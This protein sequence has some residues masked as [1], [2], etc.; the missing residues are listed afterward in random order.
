MSNRDQRGYDRQVNALA[1]APM[2]KRTPQF[3]S[4][5]L[6]WCGAL[7]C[8][9]LLFLTV[10]GRHPNGLQLLLPGLLMIMPI[11]LLRK[12]PLP[13]LAL[14]LIGS[15]G[16]A[17]TVHSY[18]IGY[19]QIFSAAIALCLIVAT[20]ARWV[21][22]LAAVAAFAVQVFSATYYATGSQ[23]FTTVRVFSGN[24]YGSQHFTT[25]VAFAALTTITAWVIGQSVRERRGHAEAL[26]AQGA[27]QA[28]MAERLRIARELHDVIA[29]S[30]GIIA[31]QAGVGR[32]VIDTQPA[33]ARNALDAI[34]A[35]SREA[36]AGLR[37]T[38]TALRQTQPGAD[39]APLGPA[40][41]LADLGRLAAATQ[42]A[43]VRMD[44]RWTG[45]RRPLP[46]DIDLAAFR[47]IQE[48]VTNVVCHAA[49]QDC[50][51]IIDQAGDELALEIVDDGQGAAVPGTGYG[52]TGMRERVG[53][54]HGQFA[55]GLRPEGGFRVA[56]RLPVPAPAR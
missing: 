5:I 26:R 31:I 7:A 54:L 14:I 2:L 24:Y 19:L 46:A 42:D 22:A 28:V 20:H 38:L 33:E 11:A 47:I 39:L 49:T 25:V 15:F 4:S 9:V 27:A 48:A 32:R 55:A 40:P 37:R 13:A 44:V 43:G 34:E 50:R 51:V 29:H 41:G 53:L 18:E 10:P 36:L 35:T 56:A 12:R 1:P 23:H 30:V 16:A 8:P 6:A 3:A 17:A 45:P 52:I 21:S